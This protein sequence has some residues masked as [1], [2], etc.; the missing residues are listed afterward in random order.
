[1]SDHGADPVGPADLLVIGIGSELHGDDAVGRVVADRLEHLNLPGVRVRSVC[2]LVPEL[3][4][5]LATCTRVVFVDAD[6]CCSEV[7]VREVSA[8]EGGTVVTHHAD[9]SGLLRLAVTVSVAPPTAL[10]IG[11]PARCL[12]L[13]SE[14]SP[15]AQDGVEV[16]LETIRRLVHRPS[17]SS[18][19]AV[20]L[21][22][23]VTGRL[24]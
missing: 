14:L 21:P 24:G 6:P 4:Q 22:S 20:G 11:V 13:G 2:Q 23:E 1:M 7:T 17:G 9:P 5:E 16:A 10:L 19:R 15:Q 18:S 8:A 3:V 12:D